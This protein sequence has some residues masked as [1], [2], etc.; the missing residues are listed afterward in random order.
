MNEEMADVHDEG[1]CERRSDGLRL[2]QSVPTGK[3]HHAACLGRERSLGRL[4]PLRLDPVEVVIGRP[5]LRGRARLAQMVLEEDA[6]PLALCL[7]AQ[8][9][10]R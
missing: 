3:H 6:H 8:R 1:V 7:V 2:P 9:V 10:S 4:L 5:W